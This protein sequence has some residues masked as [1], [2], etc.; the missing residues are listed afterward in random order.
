MDFL[1]IFSEW[2]DL[3]LTGF[4]L[5]LAAVLY[6]RRA[7]VTDTIWWIREAHRQEAILLV[8]EALKDAPDSPVDQVLQQLENRHGRRLSERDRDMAHYLLDGIN[9]RRKIGKDGEVNGAVGGTEGQAPQ[10]PAR[11]SR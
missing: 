7:L 6:R 10:E 8:V 11:R 9:Y 4:G 1:L 2:L 3:G 5:V